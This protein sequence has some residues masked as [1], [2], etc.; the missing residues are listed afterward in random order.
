LALREI[1]SFEDPVVYRHSD[2]REKGYESSAGSAGS[3]KGHR[4][5]YVGSLDR[6]SFYRKTAPSSL[7][8]SPFATTRKQ[9]KGKHKDIVM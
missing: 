7:R 2:D 9:S 5:V 6:N 1:H 4:P 3:K 8:K